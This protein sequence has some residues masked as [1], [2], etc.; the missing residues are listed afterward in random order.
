MTVLHFESSNERGG[1]ISSLERKIV[2][3]RGIAKGLI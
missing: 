3:F 2:W 1:I